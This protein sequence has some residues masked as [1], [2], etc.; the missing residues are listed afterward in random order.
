MHSVGF[1]F[2]PVVTQGGWLGEK[3]VNRPFGTSKQGLKMRE[4]TMSEKT[5]GGKLVVGMSFPSPVTTAYGVQ[6]HAFG[7]RKAV[8]IQTCSEL[9]RHTVCTSGDSE[10]FVRVYRKR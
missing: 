6:D 1:R 10:F 9:H 4:A 8:E 2:R 7:N 3:T 5:T